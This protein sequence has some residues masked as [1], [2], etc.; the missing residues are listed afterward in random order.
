MT[1]VTITADLASAV[2]HWEFIPAGDWR[3]DEDGIIY[4]PTWSLPLFD[5]DP[6]AVPNLYAHDL[7]REDYALFTEHAFADVDITVSFK[8]PYGS[9][10]NGGVVFRAQDA[11]SFYVVDI[12]DIYARSR[13][14][15]ELSLWLQQADGI[16]TLLAQGIAPHS[17][18]T[19]RIAERGPRTRAEWDRSSPDWVEV[20]VQASGTY[21]RVSVDG[22]I[23][24]E[25]RD[26]TYA[27]GYVGLVGRG[28]VYFRDL[29]IA[30]TEAPD[31]TG[32][33]RSLPVAD[34]VPA[35]RDRESA[36][37]G[38]R[39]APVLAIPERLEH[40]YPGAPQPEGFNAYP[41]ACL[42]V[43]GGL[44]AVWAH[45]PIDANPTVPRQ[46][47]LTRSADGGQTWTRPCRI[48]DSAGPRTI[49]TAL[50]EHRDGR[51]SCFVHVWPD[52]AAPA[53]SLCVR[54]DADGSGAS[55]PEPFVA[56]GRALCGSRGLCSPAVR[57]ADGRILLGGYEYRTY[58]GGDPDHF[59]DREDRSVL[60]SSTDDGHTWAAARLICGE[61][62]G[63]TD[64]QIVETAPGR[65]VALMCDQREPGMLRA[66]SDDGGGTWSAVQR[67]ALEADCPCVLREPGGALVLARRGA[68]LFVHVS[69][70]EGATWSA[71]WRLSPVSGIMVMLAVGA[72]RILGIC[73]EGYRV[74]GHVRAQF[75]RIQQDGRVTAAPA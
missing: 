1:T 42:T 17:I 41:A 61:A 46:V 7:T 56:G 69:R 33:R 59:S 35:G 74:P 48:F 72:G 24:F 25:L 43:N 14:A 64:C 31:G 22:Q 6:N 10:V 18:V 20:R 27:A 75:F 9:V 39:R 68:G 51:L 62:Y 15:Y 23:T 8:V 45:A 26:R 32:A 21:I 12:C 57:T 50:L 49:P 58:A 13:C 28:A 37:S 3:Q 70:D 63:N 52:G 55:A 44:A 4:P 54:C 16:R 66:V 19:Q 65:L 11:R 47:L 73:H 67:V 38:K 60:F 53:Q 29:A 36:G 5:P 30:G 71:P 2:Q 40:F 34:G